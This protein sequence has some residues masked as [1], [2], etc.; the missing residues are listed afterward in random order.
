MKIDGS[1]HCG[2]ITYSAEIE[3][4]QVELCHCTDCQSLSGSAYRTVAPA[5][6]GTFKLLS[7]VLKLYDKVSDEGTIRVQ[8]FC[9][10]CGSPIYSSPPEGQSGFFG[11]RVGSISQ[12]R[13]L[14][15]THQI[16]AR[17]ALSWTQDLSGM[18]QTEKQ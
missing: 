9:A 18:D 17:S 16:W 5:K 15:P 3:A 10:H 13:Q 14:V 11:I 8:S 2:H 12:R 4:D 1:C 6:E 7:G